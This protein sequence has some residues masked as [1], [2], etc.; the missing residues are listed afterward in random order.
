MSASTPPLVI[1]A[2]DAG[3]TE[4]VAR[5]CKEQSLP[6]I[7]N[8]IDRGT[9]VKITGPDLI[10][11][12]GSWISLFSGTSKSDH[13][14]YYF[15]HLIPGSYDLRSSYR[16][17]KDVQPFWSQLRDGRLKAL[18]VDPPEFPITA[19][20][21]GIQVNHWAKLNLPLDKRAL[22]AEPASLVH[23]VRTNFEKPHPV[24]SFVPDSSP[25]KDREVL[26]QALKRV[27]TRGAICRHLLT[28]DRFDL[29]LFGF[30]ETHEPGHRLKRYMYSAG[31]D[32]LSNGLHK[33]YKAIDTQISLILQQLPQASNV[34]ILS[35]YGLSDDYP[36]GGLIDP[37]LTSLGYQTIAAPSTQR[38]SWFELIREA[39]P[40][41]WRKN[42]SRHLPVPLQES[43]IASAF[44]NSRDWSK[45]K[46]F[47]IPSNYTSLVRLNVKGREPEGVIEP[48]QEYFEIL[49]SI[50][51]NAL[52]LID[53]V[54]GQPAVKQVYRTVDLFQCAID[55]PLPDMFIEWKNTHHFIDRL[56]HP[57]FEIMQDRPH[58]FRSSWHSSYGF[59]AAAGPSIEATAALSFDALDLAPTLLTLLNLPQP[60]G[61]RGKT[62]HWLCG[63]QHQR[64][65]RHPVSSSQG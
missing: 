46:A 52:Q 20:L 16:A 45:T 5:W 47:G 9:F 63:R 30:F 12:L 60:D 54:T 23:E 31:A 41:A 8:I 28:K 50:E 58:Y 48:S 61:L 17:F 33:I 34:L 53:P 35:A 25:A 2:I 51:H 24:A 6:T 27:E 7:G 3:D 18:L 32:D 39:I 56:Q 21:P 14:V 62:L 29:M 37:F 4:L 36:T 55:H 19:G 1:F 40:L 26:A 43:L 42:I 13:G 10:N 38:S 11:E 15:R 65:G 22:A 57:D 49:N 59:C 64:S 44:K